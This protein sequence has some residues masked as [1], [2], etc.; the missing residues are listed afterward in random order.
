MP[1]IRKNNRIESVEWFSNSQWGGYRVRVTTPLGNHY[2]RSYVCGYSKR[3]AL[4]LARHEDFDGSN[5]IQDW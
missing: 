2:K 1:Y 5:A 4:R 3:E